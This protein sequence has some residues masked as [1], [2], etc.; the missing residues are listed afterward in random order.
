MA[1]RYERISAAGMLM[2][3]A[4]V[5]ENDLSTT[6]EHEIGGTRQSTVVEPISDA[7]CTDQISNDLFRLSI[8]RPN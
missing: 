5:H 4:P 8:L 3:K 2:P 1:L 6:F 7:H